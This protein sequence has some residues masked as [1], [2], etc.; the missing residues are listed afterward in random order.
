MSHLFFMSTSYK[1]HKQNV[2]LYYF[3]EPA[4]AVQGGNVEPLLNSMQCS[5]YWKVE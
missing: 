1:T 5:F 2:E 4:S 3:N